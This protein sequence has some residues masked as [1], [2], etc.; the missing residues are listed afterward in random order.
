MCTALTQL[1]ALNVFKVKITQM[2]HYMES[3]EHCSLSIIILPVTLLQNEGR[4]VLPILQY[5]I[6]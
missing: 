6:S 1:L 2:L 4:Y 5:S 3:L